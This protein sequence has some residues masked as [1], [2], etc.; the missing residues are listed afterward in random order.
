MI[1]VNGKL[2]MNNGEESTITARCGNMDGKITSN[3]SWAETPTQDNQSNFSGYYE[4]QMGP[5]NTIEVN[6]DGK[7]FVFRL[8]DEE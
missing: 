8:L 4:Y 5:D 6:I 7:F 1:Q 2:Y 3:V